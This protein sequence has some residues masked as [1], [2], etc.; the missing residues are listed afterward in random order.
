MALAYPQPPLEDGTIRLRPWEARD[1][2]CVR[3]AAA[4]PRIPATTTV[5]EVFTRQ[6]GLQF[7]ERQH[8]RQ[9]NGEG[10]SLAIADARTDEAVGLIVLLL[11]PQAGVAGVGYWLVPGARGRGRAT[12]AVRLVAQWAF[13]IGMERLE[14]WVEPGNVESGRVLLAAGFVR[15]GVLRSFLSYPGRRADAIVFSRLAEDVASRD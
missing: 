2:T 13:G 3:E 11:R 9:A 14:A 15:E 1:L 6:G 5:P 7:I 4:D 10:I 8:R 12:R